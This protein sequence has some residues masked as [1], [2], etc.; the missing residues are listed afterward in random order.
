MPSV[1]EEGT[2]KNGNA[3]PGWNCTPGDARLLLSGIAGIDDEAVRA[4]TENTAPL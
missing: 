1:S 3:P 2:R 4:R